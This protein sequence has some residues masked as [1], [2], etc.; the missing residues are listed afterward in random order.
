MSEFPPQAA[1]AA[2]APIK[3]NSLKTIRGCPSRH[4]PSWRKQTW[5]RVMIDT[6]LFER[7]LDR[8]TANFVPLSP[9]SF[10][11][12]AAVIYPTRWR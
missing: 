7:D 1:T 4:P 6:N 3:D 8:N 10:L 9:L 5:I 11:R 12:R 2:G